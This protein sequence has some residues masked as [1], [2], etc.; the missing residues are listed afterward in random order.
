MPDKKPSAKAAAK[1]LIKANPTWS[2]E[3]VWAALKESGY[4]PADKAVVSEVRY[5]LGAKSPDWKE[6]D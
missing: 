1:A 3:R 4:E 5:A 6:N 2:D